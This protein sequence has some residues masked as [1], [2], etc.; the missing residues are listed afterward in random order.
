MIK[1]RYERV[2]NITRKVENAGYQNC[3]LFLHRFQAPILCYDSEF[4]GK[5]MNVED[6]EAEGFC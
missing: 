4:Y 1:F 6:K 2:G 3:L 5:G